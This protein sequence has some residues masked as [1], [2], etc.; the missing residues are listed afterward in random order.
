MH[1]N[2]LEH[3][4]QQIVALAAF[5][6]WPF[7]LLVISCQI[8]DSVTCE[9]GRICPVGFSC[10]AA[11]D[12]CIDNGCG[13]GIVDIQSGEQCDDGNILVDD[14]CSKFCRLEYCGDGVTQESE[15]CDD[16][17][18]D[19]GDGCPA[20]CLPVGTCGDG[21]V[22]VTAGEVCDDGGIEDGGFD[23]ICR[24]DCLSFFKCGNGLVDPA[25]DCDTAGIDT[26]ECNVNCTFA[27]CGDGYVNRTAGEVCEDI[28]SNVDAGCS[29]SNPNCVAKCST[30]S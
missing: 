1:R 13:D 17:N 23:D 18:T 11:Q 4:G 8:S 21:F 5:L 7:G 14:G 16:G 20:D 22:D 15:Y 2:C 3:C 24:S 19:S 9:T 25:E 10:A 6:C 27:H 29:V 26:A 30:C 28:G 12:I